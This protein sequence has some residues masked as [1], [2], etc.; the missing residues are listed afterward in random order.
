[1]SKFNVLENYFWPPAEIERKNITVGLIIHT[2]VA[3][4]TVTITQF[5]KIISQTK[6]ILGKISSFIVDLKH[7]PFSPAIATV[8]SGETG[9]DDYYQNII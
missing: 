2:P 7:Q 3:R 6:T 5:R 8:T 9:G 4:N 1:M